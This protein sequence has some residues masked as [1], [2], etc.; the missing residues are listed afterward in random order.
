MDFKKKAILLTNIYK[1]LGYENMKLTHTQEALSR[2]EGHASRHSKLIEEKNKLKTEV[3]Q[4]FYYEVHVF[5]SVKHGFSVALKSKIELDEDDVINKALSLNLIDEDD[6][7]QIDYIQDIDKES[8]ESFTSSYN[9][10]EDGNKFPDLRITAFI[11]TNDGQ[12][13]HQKFDC[14][15]DIQESINKNCDLYTLLDAKE[16]GPDMHTDIIYYNS[17]NP[18]VKEVNDYLAI[19]NKKYPKSGFGI[20]VD[21]DSF[22]AWNKEYKLNKKK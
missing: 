2:L 22:L 17:N 13:H 21:E 15:L 3:A 4:E 18:L 1:E 19:I 6:I 14:T 8:Y 5:H 9:Q 10:D 12:Y 16:Y 11:S 7:D 20:V